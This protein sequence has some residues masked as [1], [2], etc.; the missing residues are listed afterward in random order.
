MSPRAARNTKS[1]TRLRYAASCP[2]KRDACTRS[3]PSTET[4]RSGRSAGFPSSTAPVPACAAA[5]NS[6]ST[7]GARKERAALAAAVHPPPSGTRS[8]AEP[9]TA[10]NPRARPVP[11]FSLVSEAMR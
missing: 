11:N 9:D 4:P 7:V 3:T 6:S 10:R 5:E 2:V 8:P 1:D